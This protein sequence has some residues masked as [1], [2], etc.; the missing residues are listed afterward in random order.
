[1]L[2]IFGFT[3]CNKKNLSVPGTKGRKAGPVSVEVKVVQPELLLNTVSATG[4]I[5]ANEKAEIRPEISGRIVKIL[6]EEGASVQKNKLL[7]KM[8][9][10]DLQAQLKRNEAQAM[11]LNND[12]F[13]KRKLLEIKAISQDEYDVAKS[14]M[15]VNQADKQLLEAQIA[16]TE[17]FAPF[18]GKVGL[19]AVSVGNYVASNTLIATIQQLDPVKIEFDVPEKYSSFIKPGMEISFGI[20]ALDSVFMAKVYAVESA[21]TTETRTLKVRA[22]CSNKA[23]LLNPGTFARVNMI[24]ERFS[25]AI[26]V[27]SEAVMTVLDGNSVFICKNGKAVVVPVKTGIRTDR[28]I[29]ITQGV[30]AGDSLITTGLLQLTNGATVMVKK[31][32]TE[33]QT[34]PTKE[35]M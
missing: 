21:I 8:N 16:K 24:L 13:Q 12:E 25:E 17:I 35:K 26:K 4:T 27:P 30:S 31:K 3:A 5:L 10:S 23:N 19:R 18:N 14:L 6:F 33:T 22:L 9:D 32:K 29:Q 2:I 34:V 1:M 7:V 20:D 15:L 11:L 28:E